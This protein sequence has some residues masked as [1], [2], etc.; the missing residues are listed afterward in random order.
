[1]VF[2]FIYDYPILILKVYYIIKDE[3]YYLNTNVQYCLVL[4]ARKNPNDPTILN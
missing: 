4:P 3:N 1:M 2:E